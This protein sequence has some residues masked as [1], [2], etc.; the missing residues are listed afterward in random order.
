MALQAFCDEFEIDIPTEGRPDNVLAKYS[1]LELDSPFV[2]V[3]W[4]NEYGDFL[5]G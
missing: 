3:G 5:V 2:F 4:V 1:R